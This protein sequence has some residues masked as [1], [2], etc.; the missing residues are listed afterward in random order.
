MTIEGVDY[1][2]ARPSPAGLYAAGKRF[3]VRYGG[4][5]RD[6]KQLHATELQALLAAG[7]SVVANAEGAAAGY[8]GTVA[9]RAW[10]ADADEHFRALGMPAG[11]PI[12]FSVDW[13]AGPAD[14]PDIDAALRGSADVIGAARVGVYGGYATVAHCAG[15]KTAQWLWQT[16]A[17]SAGR[18]WPGAHMQQ[19]RNGVQVGGGDCDLNRAMADDFGQWGQ[20][21]DVA[22]D[23]GDIKKVAQ[24]VYDKL[25]TSVDFAKS[26]GSHSPISDAVL[27]SFYPRTPGADRTLTWQ[28]LQALQGDVTALRG[29][30]AQLQ[31]APPVTVSDAQLQAAIIAAL[32]Q[33]AAPSA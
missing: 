24:A 6:A 28:N 3:V 31:A 32:R 20:E 4:P 5:G 14:W 16:Y 21:T 7:L 23:D 15:A 29:A 27:N 25:L 18:W 12:Y 10:A 30:V 1:A 26:G 19:Y 22:L 13:N 8:R 33:L 17:W 9:G 11:R 2:D